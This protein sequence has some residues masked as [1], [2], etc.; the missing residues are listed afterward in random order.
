M[1]LREGIRAECL[2]FESAFFDHVACIGALLYFDDPD[3]AME[4][5]RRVLKPEGRLVL[6]TLNKDNPFTRRTG[7]KLDPASKNFYS[8]DELTALLES[9]G[10]T[11]HRAFSFGY[12]PARLPNLYWY[13]QNVLLSP[14]L[15]DWLNARLPEAH[16]VNHVLHASRVSREAKAQGNW[17]VLSGFD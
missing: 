15:E 1:D 9:H 2:P 5:L 10:F 13:V 6:R 12:Y 16:R 4:E 11:V 7:Q 17:P 14:R 8:I 3:K